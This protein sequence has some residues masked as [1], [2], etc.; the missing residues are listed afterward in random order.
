MRL[1][2]PAWPS[3]SSTHSPDAGPVGMAASAS[4]QCVHQAMIWVS[5][6][7]RGVEP[8][9]DQRAF[10]RPAWE[11]GTSNAGVGESEREVDT[12]A[13]SSGFVSNDLPAHGVW[14]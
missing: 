9:G 1:W 12:V 10:L 14:S 5:F 6:G 11:H 4:G 2:R 7:G 8:A 13:R 3:T